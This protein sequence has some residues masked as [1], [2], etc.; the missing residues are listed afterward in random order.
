MTP[1]EAALWSTPRGLA[2]VKALW[3]DGWP[4]LE[5]SEERRRL[6]WDGFVWV[7]DIDLSPTLK[8]YRQC[9]EVS[10][11]MAACTLK[12]FAREKLWA[13]DGVLFEHRP[14]GY[15]WSRYCVER[16]PSGEVAARTWNEEVYAIETEALFAA[17]EAMRENI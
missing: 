16:Q 14:E 10:S 8:V 9:C 12:D 13:D 17:A 4:T 2:V 15:A 11:T 6:R 3:P 7:I 5:D 1:E